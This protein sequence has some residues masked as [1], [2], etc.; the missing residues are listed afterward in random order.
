MADNADFMNLGTVQMAQGNLYFDADNLY[1][2]TVLP[3]E[4]GGDV[5]ALEFHSYD[6]DSGWLSYLDYVQLRTE[7]VSRAPIGWAESDQDL[8]ILTPSN[9]V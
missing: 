7:F 4:N 2:G 3:T 8:T 5:F 9:I 6:L 1:Q